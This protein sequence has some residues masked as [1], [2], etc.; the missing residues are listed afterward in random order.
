MFE[1]LIK[2]QNRIGPIL[3][4]I[5]LGNALKKKFQRKSA[6]SKPSRSLNMRSNFLKYF[7][8]VTL[9][10]AIAAATF[11]CNQADRSGK[12]TNPNRNSALTEL[13]PTSN[14]TTQGKIQFGG[15]FGFAKSN[16]LIFAPKDLSKAKQTIVFSPGAAIG[17]EKMSGLAGQL[18]SRG[19]VTYVVDYV[20][21]LAILQQDLAF[22]LAETLATDVT[23]VSN[24]GDALVTWH[25]SN[26]AISL[27]GHSMGGAVLGK[28]VGKDESKF[29]KSILLIGV[30]S[31]I[32]T[33]NIQPDNS[34][35][36][37]V[38]LI[39]GER[40]GLISAAESSKMEDLF[41]TLTIRVAGVN[42]FCIAD[43]GEV[44][45]KDKR[46]QDNPTNLSFEDCQSSMAQAMV[47]HLN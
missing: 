7:G 29:L 18:A 22:S 30:S 28:T 14:E 36:S 11:G 37:K 1:G 23:K 42:H 12:E 35:S 13:K 21:D 27:A 47:D 32:G 16:A 2:N 40:D 31:V 6:R 43:D 26:R 4:A 41:K 19:I 17:S 5:A 20:S 46:S 39:T 33:T 34:P 9:F 25:K 38:V 24:L 10:A 3:A 15:L 44:G 45:N 8:T